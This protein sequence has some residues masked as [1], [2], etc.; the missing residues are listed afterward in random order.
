MSQLLYKW[1]W[2]IWVASTF[3]W[4]LLLVVPFPHEVF[5]VLGDS[6]GTMRSKAA[7]G[8]HVVAYVV[9]TAAAGWLSAPMRYRFFLVFFLMVHAT[10]TEL[11]QRIFLFLGR[12]GHLYDVAWDHLGIGIG[13]ALTWRWWTRPD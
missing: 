2:W 1:R 6:E 8:L 11:V 9:L 5:S 10:S 12:T 3:M 7:K 13:L 4:T